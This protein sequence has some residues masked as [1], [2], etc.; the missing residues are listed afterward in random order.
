MKARTSIN[1]NLLGKLVYT[2]AQH[3]SKAAQSEVVLAFG[4]KQAELNLVAT[5]SICK[6]YLLIEMYD[7]HTHLFLEAK[8]FDTERKAKLD[9]RWLHSLTSVTTSNKIFHTFQGFWVYFPGRALSVACKI[10]ALNDE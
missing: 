3:S 6:H 2:H 10:Y 5:S 7:V 8:T 9:W 1:T 4:K